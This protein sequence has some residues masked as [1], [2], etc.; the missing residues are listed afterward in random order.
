LTDLGGIADIVRD[1]WEQDILPDVFEVQIEDHGAALWVAEKHGDL[2]G[3]VSAFLTLGGQGSRRWEI[4]LIAVTPASRRQG[5]GQR[6]I[7]R[8]FQDGR[9]HDAAAARAI[10]RVSN[11]ASQRAFEK[12]DFAP[13]GDVYH[14]LLWSPKPGDAPAL[15]A[16]SLPW[17]PVDTLTY[18]GLWMEGLA[19]LPRNDQR[20]VVNAARALAAR[21]QR[22]N[23][24]ALVCTDKEH[25]LAADLRADAKMHGDYYRYIKPIRETRSVR[26]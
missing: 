15:T 5:L 20:P 12:A 7:A 13:D 9:R 25:F 21:E 14:L 8:A 16:G 2:V 11:V 10:V 18:R 22:L 4:D 19:G 1:I 3:F 24:G 17:V 23:T 6:L 26:G